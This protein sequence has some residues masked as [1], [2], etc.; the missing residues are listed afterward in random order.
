VTI[1]PTILG[2]GS[3]NNQPIITCQSWPNV[4]CSNDAWIQ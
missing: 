2:S 1:I 4:W 3:P